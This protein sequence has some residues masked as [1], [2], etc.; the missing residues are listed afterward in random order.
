MFSR[1]PLASFI[2]RFD[3][4]TRFRQKAHDCKLENA[5]SG[6]ERGSE[7]PDQLT[8]ANL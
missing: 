6:T 4:I 5:G 7:I 1:D 3:P 8:K 2:H